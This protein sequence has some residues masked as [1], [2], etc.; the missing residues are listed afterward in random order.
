MELS[1]GWVGLE[2]RK[3]TLADVRAISEALKIY[4]GLRDSRHKDEEKGWATPPV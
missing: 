4:D 2:Q 1:V 3:K